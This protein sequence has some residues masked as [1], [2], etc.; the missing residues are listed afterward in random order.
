MTVLSEAAPDPKTMLKYRQ[1]CRAEATEDEP[2][3]PS[4]S[5]GCS[6]ARWNH[7]ATPFLVPQTGQI[8]LHYVGGYMLPIH[9]LY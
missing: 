9:L 5:Y 2:P 8:Q 1:I 4:F 7:L 6:K 3:R